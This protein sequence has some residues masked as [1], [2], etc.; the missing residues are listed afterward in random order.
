ML[1]PEVYSIGWHELTTLSNLEIM[2]KLYGKYCLC[3]HLSWRH[4]GFTIRRPDRME[5]EMT[6][7]AC[8]KNFCE[9]VTF[10]RD[11]L[12]YLEKLSGE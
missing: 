11:N 6:F 9:C 5:D 8:D 2:R 1:N 10:K 12:K 3:T 7:G 4:T